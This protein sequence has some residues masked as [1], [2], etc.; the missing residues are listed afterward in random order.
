MQIDA[1]QDGYT[2]NELFSLASI[3]VCF[4]FTIP[5]LASS[6]GNHIFYSSNN[7]CVHFGAFLLFPW[8]TIGSLGL[9]GG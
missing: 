5:T 3:K 8:R 1:L 4:H 6:S 9:S 2:D 7:L